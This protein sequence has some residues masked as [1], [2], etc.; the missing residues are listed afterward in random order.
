MNLN[1]EA[2]KGVAVLKTVV[3]FESME[4]FCNDTFCF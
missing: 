4:V 2:G 1:I 3:N